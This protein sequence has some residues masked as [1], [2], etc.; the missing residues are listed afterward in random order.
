MA[1]Y[2]EMPD[3]SFFASDAEGVT[4]VL[5]GFKPDAMHP[6]GDYIHRFIDGGVL[7]PIDTDRLSNWPDIAPISHNLGQPVVD[8]KRYFV[9]DGFGAS[10]LIY[11]TDLV[12][13]SYVDESSWSILYDDRYAGRLAFYDSDRSAVVV[14]ALVHGFD[15]PFSLTDAQLAE[16]RPLLEK[17][18]DLAKFYWTDITQLEQAMAQGEVVASYAWNQ[19]YQILLS[20]G[21]PVKYVAPKEGNLAFFEG[22]MIHKDATDLDRIYAF[23]DAFLAP[24]SGAWLMDNYG[25]GTFNLKS[26]DLLP[27]ERIAEL[28]Y[29]NIEAYLETVIFFSNLDP[30]VEAKYEELYT[31]VLAGA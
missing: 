13:P 31:E 4:K 29:S 28:G 20:E 10:S 2:D 26:Y 30:A 12:D 8:G 7:Q 22:W 21:V 3:Y 23:I 24:E 18:R 9:P 27:P 11:R 19:S 5:A 6:G 15:N 17:Q 25:Y 14:A 16:L 1:E